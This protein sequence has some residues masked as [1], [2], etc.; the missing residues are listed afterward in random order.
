MNF[1]RELVVWQKGMVL[2]KSIYSLSKQFPDEEKF[3]LTMQIRKSSVS[4][5][6]N[7]AEG[8]GR[9]TTGDYISFF[10]ISSGSLSE[11][12]TQLEVALMSEYVDEEKYQPIENLAVECTKMLNALIKS[13]SSKLQ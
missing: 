12:R 11:M 2:V 10:R 9:Y 7:V 1:F 5:P 13:L 4:V 6:S 3:G 8:F